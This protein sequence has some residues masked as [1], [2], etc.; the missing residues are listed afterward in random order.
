MGIIRS[1]LWTTMAALLLLATFCFSPAWALGGDD[2][3]RFRGVAGIYEGTVAL[4]IGDEPFVLRLGRGGS[5][6][7]ITPDELQQETPGMG[8]WKRVGYEGSKVKI[9]AAYEQY[10][11]E[12]QFG[13]VADPVAFDSDGNQLPVLNWGCVF[14]VALDATIDPDGN[15]VGQLYLSGSS[16]QTPDELNFTLLFNLNAKRK[17]FNEIYERA[18]GGL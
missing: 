10:F 3:F 15:L 9:R 13:C 16:A 14:H 18:R 7:L 4:S 2:D 8:L 11:T 1:Q 6:D 17:S 5:F 12:P